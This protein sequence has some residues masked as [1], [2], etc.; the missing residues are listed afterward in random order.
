M[1]KTLLLTV[2]LLTI[3]LRAQQLT[4]T[5]LPNQQELPQTEIYRIMQDSEGYMWYAT[6][7]SGLCRD[8]G[9]QIDVFRADRHDPQ[10]LESNEV[11]CMTEIPN[12]EEIWFGTK[13][14]AYI[15]SKHDYQVRPLQRSPHSHIRDLQVAPDGSVWLAA[16]QQAF[17]F[18][19]E[20]EPTDSFAL[21]WNDQPAGAQSMAF[22]SQGRLWVM[23]WR[24]GIICIDSRTRQLRTMPWDK[25]NG[26]P[27]FMAEDTLQH[28]FYI[29]TWG[30]G[31][32]R[33]DGQR[34][35]PLPLGLNGEMEQ[36][37][38]SVH[39]DGQ[40]RM[41]WVV[42][43]AGLHA[44]SML[45][46]GTLQP[47]NLSH[48]GLTAQQAIFPLTLDR[49]GNVWV[50]GTTP[51]TFILH[52]AKALQTNRSPLSA[53]ERQTG[54][55]LPI[56]ALQAEG[57]YCWMWSDRTQ[58]VLY[59]R[60]H[61]LVTPA[62]G[63]PEDGNTRFGREMTR[64]KQGG[65][66]CATGRQL[67]LC[68]HQGMQVG[69]SIRPVTTLP[70]GITT[71]LEDEHG[72]LLIGTNNG[73]YRYH[74]DKDRL[75]TLAKETGTVRGLAL[76][77]ND[78]IAFI[79]LKN[80]LCQIDRQGLCQQIAPYN[81]FTTLAYGAGSM[82][83]VGNAFGDVWGV[84]DNGQLGQPDPI[85]SS[86]KGHGVKKLLCD[87]AGHLWI[88]G[89]AYLKEYDPLAGGCRQL[90]ASDAD[91][92]MDNFGSMTLTQEGRVLMAGGGALLETQSTDLIAR[93]T[94]RLPI[95]A[96][97]A[98]DGTQHLASEN[99]HKTIT[100]EPGITTL[101]LQ[102]TN[103]DYLN[104]HHLQ[105][106]YC[107]HGLSE[108]WI[109]LPRGENTVRLLNLQRGTYQMELKVCDAMGH[110]SEP[111]KALTIDRRPAWYE[112]WPAL[113][114]YLLLIVAMAAWGIRVYLKRSKE[115]AQRQMDEQL[116]EMKLRFFTNVS[117][118]LRTPL[119]LVITP[120]ESILGK[121]KK[122]EDR[123]NREDDEKLIHTI[124]NVHKHANELLDLVNRLLDFRKLDMGELKL[125]PSGGDLLEFMRACIASFQP[126]AQAKG[127]ALQS[128]IPEG[129]L[130]TD[131]DAKAMQHVMYN[132]LSNAIKYTEKGS[133]TVKMS[134][135]GIVISDT[136]TGISADELPHIF[137]RYYQASNADDCS[138]TGTG[139]GLNMTKELVEKMGGSISVESTPG[140]GSTFTVVLPLTSKPEEEELPTSPVIPKL[141][142]LL[143]ADDNDDFRDFLVQELKDD[144]NILQ[145]RNG[146]EALKMAQTHYVDV[147]L[148]D[149]M[150]PQMDGNELCRRLKQD[151][152]TSHILIILLTAKTAE[153]S[154]LEGY[155]SG[156]DYYLTKPFSLEL[157][158]NRLKN[159]ADKQQE[160]II[161]LSKA[162][163]Q[164]EKESEDELRISPID[165]KFMIKMRSIMENHVADPD[166]SV[167]V[168]CAEMTMSRMNFYRKM[169][170]LTGQTPAQFISDYRL[171]MAD[172]LLREGELNVTEVADRTGFSTA[173]YFSKC[174]KAK[175]GIAPKDVKAK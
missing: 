75:D 172:Q 80:G 96:A 9:Y 92:A 105:F 170:A 12:R 173:S 82:L 69:H 49:K 140:K 89:D 113:L 120:L 146:R 66:W 116:T 85:A 2:L 168:F 160:R 19:P 21:T 101:E 110:W 143:I 17:R 107:L 79:S 103:F 60:A 152:S 86:S 151:E 115:Q 171:S 32:F 74:A 130:Y 108:Q 159:M 109:T 97:W 123:R 148:S 138:T 46:D 42:T 22:D 47:Y 118:E 43:M 141:P 142:S 55:R 91:V 102:L 144:Y 127:L 50:P 10:L 117:H 64:R 136:G 54:V 67:Y 57:D 111:T 52:T 51:L 81:R 8:N 157:L 126:I 88:M 93:S 134:D 11:T 174:Y 5:P 39:I 104:A 35:E 161:L 131:F 15:L 132:L 99:N 129:S 149:V 16:S 114:A 24:G 153:E 76:M 34:A 25:Q 122:G 119:S 95:V 3:T 135:R 162:E 124:S 100:V 87:Q 112:S 133:V 33:Y 167:D 13:L 45:T 150:M 139:I 163:Q 65:V 7:G 147:I 30:K 165:R 121:L 6:R 154:R 72:Q 41:L 27:T 14:G 84:S 83:W 23:Q 62:G 71:M 36:K 98:T 145:A 90:L 38:R 94:P 18:T 56:D 59:D 28:I 155:K 166:F 44:Y 106:A 73:L 70:D 26:G 78:R 158:K 169:H 37:V 137:D 128:E 58:L 175:Y 61:G 48:L 156:A 40:R 4:M 63:M 1:K 125:H 29:A 77:P 53:L 164:E 68:T 31:V 20:G